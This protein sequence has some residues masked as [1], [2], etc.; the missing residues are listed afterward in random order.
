MTRRGLCIGVGALAMVGAIHACAPVKLDTRTVF[1]DLTY[2]AAQ[3]SPP[4]ATD[5]Q[6]FA[7]LQLEAMT[8]Y[9][10]PAAMAACLRKLEPD[11][12]ER[13]GERLAIAGTA[14]TH[15]ARDITLSSE[16][17]AADDEALV[18][19]AISRV[20]NAATAFVRA[21]TLSEVE[22]QGLYRRAQVALGAIAG[23]L[24]KTPP[25][26]DATADAPA[27]A[28]S[29]GSAN[30]AFTAGFLF[31]LL[32]LRERALPETG[33]GGRYRFSAIVGTSVGSLLAQ[34][35]DLYFVDPGAPIDPARRAALDDCNAYWDRVKVPP[36]GGVDSQTA[37][38]VTCFG[39]WPTE[40]E[41][42]DIPRRLSGLDRA[43]REELARK[44]PRQ[45]CVLTELY[46]YFTDDDEP[47]LMC[48][49]PGSV[50]AAV[51]VLGPKRP[52]LV[53][54]DPMN[55]N[56]L[57][58]VLDDFS[59]EMVTNDV[60]RVVVS[61]EVQ[62][63]QILGLDERVCSALPS[64]KG[65]P[66]PQGGREYCLSAGVMASVVLPFFARPVR[67]VYSGLTPGGECGTWFDGGLRSGFPTYRALRMTRPAMRPFVH[68]DTV[69]LRV[70]AVD[71]GRLEGLPSARPSVIQDVAFNAVGQ[72]SS[73]NMLD[74]VVIAQHMALIREQ[75]LEE[76]LEG[77]RPQG[78]T[79][80]G[81]RPPPLDEN[82]RVSA[83]FVPADVPDEIIAD[84]GYSFDRYVM[85]GLWVWGRAV[86][87]DR[88][89]GDGKW[90]AARTRLLQRL[91]WK[92]LEPKAREIARQ[93][94]RTLR[95]W[96]DAYSKPECPAHRDARMAAGRNRIERC[97]ADC[98]DVGDAGPGAS[99]RYFVCPET[100]AGR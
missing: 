54:F 35:L 4:A 82:A 15:V 92:D 21:T 83:V 16:C 62:Q 2:P 13:T 39:G 18:R 26:G 76:I 40:T 27:L 89:L 51:G 63:N 43:T 30:G 28:L 75:Q 86:A 32:S 7:A 48:V 49:E 79:A 46:R 29:G 45:M 68:D 80:A 78:E 9:R 61:V 41:G 85:R 81:D 5:L 72:M 84:A 55:D 73:Q 6:L 24:E 59:D 91:G 38:D 31:E 3:S 98:K 8:S 60:P 53:R 19:Y 58:K 52:N 56:I 44:R 99:P 22:R 14:W 70:L 87:L 1:A 71:T 69:G 74:E 11:F 34:I 37:D 65:T 66:A 97:V 50:T 36:C 64:K 67:H 12:L 33:D 90:D 88:V 95:P 100:A 42:M 96:F 17:L 57:E 77:P 25:T 20:A 93:D 47:T 94:S 10:H 23:I